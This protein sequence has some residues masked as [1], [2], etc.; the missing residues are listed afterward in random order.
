MTTDRRVIEDYL[1]IREISAEASRE[2][3]IRHGHVS[4][5]HLWWAR[6]PLVACRTAVF[7][8]L[9]PAPQTP[10]ERKALAQEMV[11]LCKW[12]VSDEAIARARQRILEANGGVTPK[13]LDMF[14]GGG[15]IPLEALRL[16]C[17]AYALELNP[18]AH[19]IEL[20]TLVYPQ[21]YG[22]ELAKDV[23]K[24]GKWVLKRVKAEISDLYPPLLDPAV[25]GLEPTSEQLDLPGTEPDVRQLRLKGKMLSPV[26]YLWTRTVRCPNPACGAMVPLYRQTWLCKKKGRYIA[27]KATPDRTVG[28]TR[29]GRPQVRF[30]VVHS[31]AAAEKQAI[32]EFGFDPK[33]GSRRGNT[34]CPFCG[35]TVKSDYVKAEGRAGGIGAQPM[36]VVCTRKGERGKVYLAANEIPAVLWP[37][38][39]GIR[40]RIKRLCV[41]TGLTVPQEPIFAGD[42][43]AFFTHLYGLVRFGDLFTPRQVLA[44]LTFTKHV[45]AAHQAMLAQDIESKRAKAITTYLAMAVTTLSHYGSSL[46]TWLYEH[47]I[48]AFIQG[49]ALPMRWDFA[50]ACPFG[51]LVGTWDQAIRKQV[52]ALQGRA[53]RGTRPASVLRGSATRLH[54]DTSFFEAVIT[55]PP[56]YDNIPYANLSDF[57]YVWLKRSVGN[58]YPEHFA[59][60]VTPKKQEAVADASR[61]GG[62][63]TAARTAYEAMMLESFQQARRVLKPGGPLVVIYAHKTTA[64]W[65]AL[66]DALRNAEFEVVEAWPLHMERAARLRAHESAALASNISII[67]RRRERQAV[68]DYVRDVRPQLAEIVRER[69]ETLIAEG[70]GG[71]D[72]VIA[73]V[74]AGLR[75]YTQYAR[76]ELA[77]GKELK[78]AAYLDEVQREVAEVVLEKVMGV[79]RRGVGG[80]DPRT[81]YYVLGRYQY[82]TAQVAFDEANVLARGVGV[83][84][85]APGGL[86]WGRSPLVEKKK[87]KVR[88]RDYR[89]RGG[90]EALGLPCN[91][92]RASLV[93]VLHRLLWLAEHA[94]LEVPQFLIQAQPDAAQLR[95]VAQAL[96]GRAL[97][98]EPTPGAMRDARTSEQGAIDRLLAAWK[99]VVEENLFVR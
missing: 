97:A 66:I 46:S 9:V 77:S 59:S 6:R 88:L 83:E 78:A 99:R 65:S 52:E 76:V 30:S 7:G 4:T 93:D 71:A 51:Y 50:E 92:A 70:I 75:A 26:A 74:G 81:R 36:A 57:F 31:A 80:V 27:L 2:K 82:G 43:R 45:H 17:E 18:V 8:A 62:D 94:P 41:E 72:L 40:A 10:E 91:G 34:T 42:S 39:S 28:V 73:T 12:K 35:S 56:Y 54:Y 61:H 85:D 21:R 69:V 84:L 1:P 14:A 23:E 49:Q 53:L 95:L 44:L 24:W 32:L 15:S 90:D 16:G 11:E 64:G 38:D 37:N 63:Q 55:D 5:L 33:T 89:E 48:S 25:S 86:T 68:G 47:M 60:E 58:L 3:S 22:P 13:V 20:C 67:A 19:L 98:D 79:D 29:S 87:D 96:A